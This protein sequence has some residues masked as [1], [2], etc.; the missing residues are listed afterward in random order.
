MYTVPQFSFSFFV[1]SSTEGI[2]NAMKNDSLV[3][4]TTDISADDMASM[5]C[6]LFEFTVKLLGIVPS[7]CTMMILLSIILHSKFPLR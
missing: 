7:L 3:L 5:Q 1:Y 2:T 6:A 4:E